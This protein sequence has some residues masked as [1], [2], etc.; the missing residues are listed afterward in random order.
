MFLFKKIKELE[1]ELAL[2][3]RASLARAQEFKY[4]IIDLKESIDLLKLNSC[5]LSDMKVI[6]EDLAQNE[7]R[8]INAN[9]KHEYSLTYEE[10][11]DKRG[12]GTKHHIFYL[13]RR[14][15]KL[16]IYSDLE[17]MTEYEFSDHAI[18]SEVVRK[19]FVL[20][21]AT[22]KLKE[23]L[24]LIKGLEEVITTASYVGSELNKKSLLERIGK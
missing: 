23:R 16:E 5:C 15:D 8:E 14:G 11:R 9:I 4:G 18:K 20:Y 24:P 10:I 2:S 1:E 3:I 12:T 13:S 6:F 21:L 22:K 7:I 19:A 17:L